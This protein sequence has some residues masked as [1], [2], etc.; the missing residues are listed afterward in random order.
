M[1]T[2]VSVQAM[3]FGNLGDEQRHRRRLHPRPLDRR[4]ALLRRV[5]GQRPGRGRGRRHP[6]AAAADHRHEGR[7]PA[8]SLP[9]MEEVM[10]GTFA[11]LADGVRPARGA[12]SRHAGHRV[13]GAGAAGSGSCR[14]GR[15]KRTTQAALKIAVEHGRGRPDRPATRRSCGSSPPRSTS[16]CIRCSIPARRARVI[17]QR[18]AGLAG[19]GVGQGRV[20]RRRGRAP[21]GQ[22]RGGD[23]GADRDLARGH[24]RH[25]CR[26]AA[27]SPRAAA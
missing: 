21:G 15:G 16:C 20:Q 19:R 11:E 1:G 2:A 10:P 5:P 4:E 6:H 26:Q 3:V 8:A 24:P 22:G 27:S 23:P 7:R 9:A 17:A 14:P 18:P 25:A 12:L 13:H